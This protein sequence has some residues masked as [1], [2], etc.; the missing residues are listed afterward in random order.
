MDGQSTSFSMA[1]IAG[2][3]GAFLRDL[4]T[5]LH[6]LCYACVDTTLHVQLIN[7]FYADFRR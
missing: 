3:G 7:A 6:L 5:V 2:M 4:E 1:S